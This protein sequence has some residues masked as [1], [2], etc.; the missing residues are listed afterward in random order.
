MKRL[1]TSGVS[2]VSKAAFLKDVQVLQ[3]ASA[4]CQRVCQVLGC[5]KVD[6]DPCI[7]MSMSAAKRLEEVEVSFHTIYC[8]IHLLQTRQVQL[9]PLCVAVCTAYTAFPTTF[10]CV[11][12]QDY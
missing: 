9:R 12:M 8:L 2:S 1:D 11:H 5:C 10:S 3:L 4:T 6:G 7:V